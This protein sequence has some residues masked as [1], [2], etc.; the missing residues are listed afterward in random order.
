VPYL[1]ARPD[2]VGRWREELRPPGGFLVGIA[3]KGNP[4]HREDRLRSVGLDRFEPLA[5]LPGVRL[6]GLQK[7]PGAEQIAELAGRLDVADLG[8]R[9]D[10]FVDTAAVMRNLD[11]VVSVDSA[12]AHLAGA[13]GVP[14]WVALPFAPDW[15]WL[16]GREDSP[17]YPS[18]RLFRQAAPGDWDGVFARM[19][20]ALERWLA[21]EPRSGPIAV[22]IGPGELEDRIAGLR[23][24]AERCA[25]AGE[26]EVAE[27]ELARL[28]AV[29]RRAVP[30]S[31]EVER[32][33]AE[34]GALHEALWQL[35]EGLRGCER[36][37]DFGGHFVEL[38]RAACRYSE[39]RS[40]LRRR[41]D[42]ML[43]WRPAGWG[44][45]AEAGV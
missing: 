32:L 31:G 3:W 1:E 20:E 26:R 4:A 30:R 14:T 15:R 11:L 8:R 27:G 7:G 35:E 37:A 23:V 45:S 25:D 12:P 44:R 28:A 43:A 21:A 18:M 39:E 13:L 9:L 6:I 33:A 41:I 17:W 19:A 5:R 2:L 36:S 38:A 34:L 29:R 22:A 40:A 24:R 16:L 10:D 42:E